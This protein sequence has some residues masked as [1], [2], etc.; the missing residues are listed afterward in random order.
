MFQK[1]YRGQNAQHRPGAGLGLY[2]VQRI[3]KR[4]KGSVAL[5]GAGGPEPVRFS[6]CLPR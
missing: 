3:A 5:T 4:L 1:Y 6:L 2:L